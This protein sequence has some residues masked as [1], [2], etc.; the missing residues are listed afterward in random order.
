M[1]GGGLL[2]GAHLR[3]CDPPVLADQLEADLLLGPLGEVQE[4]AIP[5]LQA[6]QARVTFGHDL[7]VRAKVVLLHA[8]DGEDLGVAGGQE[9]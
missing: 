8:S 4:L 2:P 3:G 1:P 6:A 9:P 5:A 7:P